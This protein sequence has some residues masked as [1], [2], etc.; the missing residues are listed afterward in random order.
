MSPAYESLLVAH[1]PFMDLQSDD[2]KDYVAFC[3]NSAAGR[4]GPVVKSRCLRIDGR[5]KLATETYIL[6]TK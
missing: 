5:T 1:K 3:R 2:A 4:V 6:N